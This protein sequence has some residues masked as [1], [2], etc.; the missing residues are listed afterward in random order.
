MVLSEL[1]AQQA[2]AF[3][4]VVMNLT[5][6]AK[7]AITTLFLGRLGELEL[8]SGTLGFMFANVTS[9]SI[10]NGLCGAM[11]PICGQAYGANNLKL[12]H[13]TL[14]MMVSLLLFVSLFSCFLWLNV[15]KILIS[16][17]QQRDISVEAKKYL[18]YL[19]PDLII[20]SFLCPLKSYLSSQSITL[21]IMF[22]SA[23]AVLL[24]VPLN[25]YLSKTRGFQGVSM[26]IWITDLVVVLL[27]ALYVAVAEFRKGGTWKEGGW[28]DHGLQDWVRLLKLC[29]PCCLTT[30][31]EW[32]CYE[33]LVLLTGKLP[34]AKQ[35]VSIIAIVLN[36]DYLLFG[37][38]LSLATCASIRVSNELGANQAGPA[39]RAAYISLAVGSVAGLSGG[40][41]MVLARGTWGH[42]FSHDKG[43]LRGARNAMLW[44][45]LL[46]VVNFP[47]AVC[48]GIVRGTA[49]PWLGMYANIG[50]FYL[51]ALP[52]GVVLAFKL[53]M[54]LPGL[55]IG[56]LAGVLGCL[57]LLLVFI[58]RIN[59][60]EEADKA[61][62][63]AS[64]K[65][66][67]IVKA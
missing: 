59:W 46:E 44:M 63:L 49:R 47:L 51:L 38:M 48:G 31:L 37:V 21:P 30:C 34:N 27:L 28:F 7:I 53:H 50:G 18:F 39:Y 33:I 20:T 3:P 42:L 12:L 23:L 8:A 32:W 15:D 64:V 25:I 67:D 24:H 55:L 13:K 54:G 43:I 29:G 35:A 36:F 9:F 14:V 60:S 66:E 19:L 52:L 26:A 62:R 6:F 58:S 61:Q 57:T 22:T 40:L 17:G 16:F 65:V 5:W 2:I 1:K 10:L 45:G 4:L 56:F 11:E 41:V